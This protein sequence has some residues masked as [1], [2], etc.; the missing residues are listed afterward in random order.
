LASAEEKSIGRVSLYQKVFDSPEGIEVLNDLVA[1]HRV[2]SSTFDKDSLQMAF[3][4]GE[5]NVIL[6]ILHILNLDV[7]KLRE[8]MRNYAQE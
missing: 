7:A 2:L 1:V 8:R 4:E 5:R 3:N 6:R